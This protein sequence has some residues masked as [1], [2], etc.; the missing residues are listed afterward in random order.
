MDVGGVLLVVQATPVTVI[1][2][3]PS[4]PNLNPRYPA[5]FITGLLQRYPAEAR[6]EGCNA[7][8]ELLPKIPSWKRAPST[9]ATTKIAQP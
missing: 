1:V 7:V 9:T 5:V 3:C 4:C 8:D 2:L 6:Q